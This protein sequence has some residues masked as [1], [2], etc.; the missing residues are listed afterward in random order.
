MLNYRSVDFIAQL[1][2]IALLLLFPGLGS[3]FLVS[4]FFRRCPLK[5]IVLVRDNEEDDLENH[6]VHKDYDEVQFEEGH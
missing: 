5:A 6:R 4:L 2:L 1:V 3:A